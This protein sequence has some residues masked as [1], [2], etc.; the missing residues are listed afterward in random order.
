VPIIIVSGN[1]STEFLHQA[2]DSGAQEVLIKPV[3]AETLVNA[4][5]KVFEVSVKK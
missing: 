4:I 3:T 2:R 1:T 5:E